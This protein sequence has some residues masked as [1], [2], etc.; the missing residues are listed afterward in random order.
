M[1]NSI[2]NIVDCPTYS[3]LH[4][5]G[6]PACT[7]L[8]NHRHVYSKYLTHIGQQVIS[9]ANLTTHNT[10]PLTAKDNA[11]WPVSFSAQL[12]TKEAVPMNTI[13][14]PEP[15]PPVISETMSQT[16]QTRIEANLQAIWQASLDVAGDELQILD[17]LRELEKLHE[18][19]RDNLF[20]AALP[21]N[22]QALYTLVKDMES[23]GGWPY[24][25]RPRLADLL[26]NLSQSDL[27]LVAVPPPGNAAP[28]PAPDPERR[29]QPG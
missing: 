21:D 9:R 8:Q 4:G 22:R 27:E 2:S 6:T 15:S 17:I 23:K 26:R 24:I 29:G 20:Q 13:P 16:P 3:I 12:V 25:Y 11:T 1:Q 10:V 14:P 7:I 18:A 19:I 5:S 28:R